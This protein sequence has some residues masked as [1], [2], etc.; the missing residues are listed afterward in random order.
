MSL[1]F[2]LL[3]AQIGGTVLEQRGKR[4]AFK[5]YK[6]GTELEI[7]QIDLRLK[8]EQ[9]ASE[10]QSLLSVEKVREVLASQQALFAAQKRVPGVGSTAAI[11]SRTIRDFNRD[12]SSRALS[13]GFRQQY[14]NAQKAAKRMSIDNAKKDYKS[15]MFSSIFN[16]IPFGTLFGGGGSSG[17]Q[18]PLAGL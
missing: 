9:L 12:E 1:E 10:E 18:S 2:L 13:L 7:A 17:S 3:A 14:L 5:E 15:D 6:K 11:T 16:K 8:Q 4:R